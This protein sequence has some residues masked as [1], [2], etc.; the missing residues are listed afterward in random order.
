MK[1]PAYKNYKDS[2]V[3]WIGCIPNEWEIS[4]LKRYLAIP[5]TD[6]PHETPEFLDEG[7]PF[8]SAEAI[9]DSKIDFDKKRGHITE[10][11]N[12]IYS[13]K[14]A[15]KRNDIYVVKSG[16]TTGNVAIVETDE[17]FNIW[18]PLAAI[19]PNPDEISCRYLFHFLRSGCFKTSIELGWSFGTQQNIGMN[20]IENL[21]V[22]RPSLNEQKS[23]AAFLDRKTA[24]IDDL[25]GKKEIL[26]KKLAEKRTALI[27]HAVTKGLNPSAPMKE[28][29][30]DW[31][32]KVPAHW[33]VKRFKF[34][35]LSVNDKQEQ[36]AVDKPYMGLE[37]VES[38]TTKR[39]VDDESKSEGVVSLFRERDILFGKLRPYLAKV[40]QASEDGC[41]STEFLVLRAAN[42]LTPDFLK[43]FILNGDFIK[44]VDAS[45][46]GSKMP[47][48]SWDFIG[49]QMLALPPLSEQT[50]ITSFLD[51]KLLEAD[52][53]ATAVTRAIRHLK[54]YRASLITNAVTGKIRVA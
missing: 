36:D 51:Q 48:A 18:S 29:G 50:A 16:A 8:I 23:I 54:E 7:V 46:Y 42:E 9:K 22:V 19:R 47:R 34:S 12:A 3:V 25:I 35:C 52:H 10:E 45:T 11:L 38:W 4:A 33:N 40:Y 53:V 14:Y 13:K 43:F 30:A 6:G 41:A 2:G 28:S 20:V 15:P 39:I 49:N 21:R 37:H 27:T 5:V 32:G 24:E 26:L 44:L 31:L 1:Y 17:T